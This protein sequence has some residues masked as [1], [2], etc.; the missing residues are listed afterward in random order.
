[1]QLSIIIVN[2]NVRQFLENALASV[3]KG[4]DGIE[5]EVFVVDNASDDGS[6]EMVKAKFP[7]VQLIAS[8]KNLGFARANNLAL[9]KARGRFLLLLNPDTILQEDTLRVMIRFMEKNPDAGLAGCKI[10]NPDGSFQLSCR[11]SFPTPWV[12]FTKVFGLSGL[13]PGSRLFG[14]YNLTY[15]NP[16]ATYPV[17]AVSGSFM[18]LTREAYEKV[19][20][21]DESFF[22][23][24]EDL[25][26]CYRIRSSG[27]RVYYVH[28]T[29]IIHFKGESTQRSSIDEIEV[30]YEAMRVFVRK[31]YGHSFLLSAF[32]SIGITLRAAAAFVARAVRPLPVV[33]MDFLLVTGSMIAGEFLRYGTL[34]T[35][36]S[37][38]YPTAWIV[39]SLLVVASLYSLG[40]YTTHRHSVSRSAGGVIASFIALSAIVFFAKEYGF[41]RIVVGIAGLISL[42]VV[43]GWRLLFRLAGRSSAKRDG[44]KSLFGR[45]T[46][47]VGTGESA[48]TI[49]RKLRA[50]VSDGYEVVGFVST[51]QRDV[52]E[53]IGGLPVIGTTENV[54]K[55]LTEQRITEVIFS[56]DGISF[57]DM[58]SV[59]ARSSGRGA[60][61]RLVPN[62]LE[63]IIGKASID[64]LDPMP[65][66]E[67]DYNIHRFSNQ[68]AKRIFDILLSLL[69]IVTI[70]P[71]R[72]L[73]QMGRKESTGVSW[74]ANL[75]KVLGGRLSF[76]GLP[77][78]EQNRPNGVRTPEFLNGQAA[79][80]GPIGLTGLV[81]IQA[82]AEALD[83]DETEKL[84][85][86]YARNQSIALDVEILMKSIRNRKRAG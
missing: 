56:T 38:A 72:Q 21:L 59:I 66:V 19:G 68:T 32:L 84:K 70:Y 9:T 76:V 83:P 62:S 79:P 54:G 10:L 58:L 29:Q 20:G 46:V 7:E 27:F 78:G 49:I 4:T 18:F 30:F 33:L 23:Y 28:E 48:L 14:R 57:K 26:Y 39:P 47:I 11:R 64:E 69:L 5:T 8:D 50:R 86:Y 77:I 67:I 55:V 12:S 25:D 41:S 24:G 15:L 31:H 3:R 61:F 42:M 43:P 35:L 81:Q 1:M 2:Y 65:L 51:N 63:A 6:V 73:F 44:R 74:I 13:F 16:D 22:M 34:F 45:R 17:D 75:P 71:V 82:D 53:V 85:L 40:V 60:N 52:G 37:Y 80:L 36:P